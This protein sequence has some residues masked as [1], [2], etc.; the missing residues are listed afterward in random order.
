MGSIFEELKKSSELDR[1]AY[2][3]Y[4]GSSVHRK[5]GDWRVNM[6]VKN[7]KCTSCGFCWAYCPD[8]SILFQDG[9]MVGFD[10]EHCK[11][12]GICSKVCPV[13]C[14]TMVKEEK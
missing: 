4:P 13:K 7:D 2:L 5:T 6:P 12:C 11:G 3:R 14:I 8:T 9:K 10:Y 1:G